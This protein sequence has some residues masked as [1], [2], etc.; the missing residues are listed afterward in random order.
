MMLKVGWLYLGVSNKCIHK[1][2]SE[3]I[4][5]LKMPSLGGYYS[6]PVY[7]MSVVTHASLMPTTMITVNR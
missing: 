3:R 5:Q 7:V 1:S 6:A 4:R 2:K